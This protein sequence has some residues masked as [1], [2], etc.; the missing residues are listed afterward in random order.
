MQ[1]E[2]MLLCKPNLRFD[3]RHA[4]GHKIGYDHNEI[5]HYKIFVC[6]LHTQCVV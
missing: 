4:K 6:D 3:R 1:S 2:N 5:Y